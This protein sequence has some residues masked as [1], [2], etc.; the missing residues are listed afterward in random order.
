[1]CDPQ[2]DPVARLLC[3]GHVAMPVSE[4]AAA[5]GPA[6]AEPTALARRLRGDGRFVVFES[7]T[8]LPGAEAWTAAD[9]MAYTRVLQQLRLP[10]AP[11]VV[12]RDPAADPG[13][14]A[15][16]D[17]LLRETL[18]GLAD[19]PTAPSIALAAEEARAALAAV[20]P[21]ASRTAPSTTPPPGPP[22]G[23]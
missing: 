13:S 16:L 4:V 14:A 17:R 15:S 20:S 23:A 9:R 10:G 3:A 22:P 18:L 5:L 2:L 11:L 6:P 7:A 1:M 19:L 21:L 12:L 8:T